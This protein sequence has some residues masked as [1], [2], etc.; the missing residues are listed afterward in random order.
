[1][2]KTN[3]PSKKKWWYIWFIKTI[4]TWGFNNKCRTYSICLDQD[5]RH[6][7]S[8]LSCL[9]CLLCFNV[10]NSFD[11]HLHHQIRGLG[12]HKGWRSGGIVERFDEDDERG[13]IWG[14]TTND[15]SFSTHSSYINY[16]LSLK[17]WINLKVHISNM[18]RF[19]SIQVIT[20]SKYKCQHYNIFKL[21]QGQ[22]IVVNN[23]SY[24]LL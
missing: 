20:K 1:M 10:K 21:Q 4:S 9:H 8:L 23:V 16:L 17:C 18:R 7:T 14:N 2:Y 6:H 5:Y 12:L 19:E 24:K 15:F 3:L 11:H 22:N 13:E